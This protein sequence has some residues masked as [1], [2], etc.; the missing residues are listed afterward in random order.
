MSEQPG[1]PA[2]PVEQGRDP[3]GPPPGPSGRPP[4]RQSAE[5]AGRRAMWLGVAALVTSLFFYPLG[6]VVGVA[7]LVIGI[8][9][10]RQ[11]RA[12]RVIAPGAVPGIVL[13]S[14]GLGLAVLAVASTAY[15]WPELSG[16]QDC[17][18]AANTGIDKTACKHEYYPKIEKKLH[19]PAGSMN[20]YGDYF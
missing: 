1:R 7:A 4:G 14:V 3:A 8:R 12:A 11:A 19:A 5:Q 17:L 15:L 16:Y 10:R 18:G 2:H 20:K 9:A 13:G 6:L